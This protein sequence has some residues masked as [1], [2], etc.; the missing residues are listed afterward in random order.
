MYNRQLDFLTA[1]FPSWWMVIFIDWVFPYDTC[2][3]EESAFQG[4]PECVN[5]VKDMTECIS[6]SGI[7]STGRAVHSVWTLDPTSPSQLLLHCVYGL[8]G[9]LYGY[10]FVLLRLLSSAPT[11]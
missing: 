1:L 9:D 10:A 11:Y 3:L 7:A 4:I 8:F 5:F 6:L 2:I